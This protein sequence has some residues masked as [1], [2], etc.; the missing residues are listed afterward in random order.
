MNVLRAAGIFALVMLWAGAPA[1]AVAT[2]TATAPLALHYDIYARGFPVMALDFRLD[3][4]AA[5]YRIAGTIHPSGVVAWFSNFTMRTESR[6]AVAAD[7]LRPEAHETDS[8]GRRG[9]RRAQLDYV[10]DG[11]ILT[12]LIPPEDPGHVP[13]SS[14]QILGTV[15]PLTAILAM[16]HAFQRSG[17]CAIAVPVFDGRRRYDL[18]LDEER[19]ETRVAAAPRRCAVTLAKIAGFSGE[20]DDA[21]HLVHGFVWIGAPRPGAPPLPVRIEFASDWGPI[22]VELAEPRPAK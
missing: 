14:G 12:A 4:T 16:S 13:P 5:Q 11:R 2:A 10:A 21:P 15:D 1:G 8:R 18:T 22:R 3:E 7:A 20:R 17:S 19:R 6:G 9:E